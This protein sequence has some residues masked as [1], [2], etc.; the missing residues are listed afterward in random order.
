MYWR[1]KSHHKWSQAGDR[2][3]KYFHT[4]TV[5][6]QRRNHISVVEN[7]Q[8]VWISDQAGVMTEFQNFFSSL[9]S[10][11]GTPQAQFVSSLIPHQV[12]SSM[13]NNLL[14]PFTSKE[15]KAALFDMYPSKAPGYDGM[16]AGFFQR[17]WDI[18][19]LDVCR[20]V[21]SFFHSGGCLV[22]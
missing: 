9:Y 22:V 16:T 18:V 20:A 11:E 4:S 19:G 10:S 15:I 12:T 21:Q 8:G 7:G 14:K 17:Y 2:N 1:Q 3:T 6:R 5:A 13:N